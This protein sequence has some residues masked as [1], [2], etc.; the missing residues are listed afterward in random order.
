[1]DNPINVLSNNHI[2]SS[3]IKRNTNSFLE[4]AADREATITLKLAKQSRLEQVIP[5][6]SLI[7]I[8]SWPE[9]QREA[10]RG[11][12][13]IWVD[14]GLLQTKNLKEEIIQDLKQ[15][16]VEDLRMGPIT[17]TKSCNLC[18]DYD[19]PGHFGLITFA[20]YILNPIFGSEIVQVLRCVC[21]VCGALLVNEN[22]MKVAGILKVNYE[23][24]LK[25]LEKFCKGKSC[26]NHGTAIKPPEIV[27][28][29]IVGEGVVRRGKPENDEIP[30]EDN[31][32]CKI[33]SNAL[34]NIESI[35]PNVE[36]YEIL[37]KIT[38]YDA[39]LLGF[40]KSVRRYLED[41]L[42]D[43]KALEKGFL[44]PSHPRDMILQGSLVPPNI[45]RVPLF[46]GSDFQNNPITISYGKIADRAKKLR[47]FNGGI[48]YNP[49]ASYETRVQ[50]QY[51]LYR[52][53]LL[54]MVEAKK[55]SSESS[56]KARTPI[57]KLIQGKK[58]LMRASLMGKTN[59]YCARTVAGPDSDL[60][61]GQ[62]RLPEVWARVLT[63]RVTVNAHNID[64]LISLTKFAEPRIVHIIK[65]KSG[66]RK[67]YSDRFTLEIGDKVDRWLT[68]GDRVT[69]NRQPTLH[70]Q[71]LMAYEVVLKP[72]LTIGL[73]LSYTSPMNAD[74]DGDE[75]NTWI[76]QDFEVEAE[77]EIL[78]NVKH[79]LM[80]AE[81]NRPIMGLVMNSVSG[82][83]L[84]SNISTRIDDDLFQELFDLIDNP[85]K[86]TLTFRLAKYGVNARSGA[87]ILSALLP[88][89]FFY[90]KKKVLIVEGV[91]VSGRFRKGS[92]GPSNR[93][94][95]QDLY[96]AY[97]S[98]L[99]ARFFTNANWIINKWIYERGFTVGLLDMVNLK[100][101]PKTNLEY[102]ANERKLRQEL[103]KVYVE[104]EALNEVQ[105]DKI[106]EE[107]RIKLITNISNVANGIGLSLANNV[108]TSE[109]SIGVMTEKGAGT[110]GSVANIG[111]MMGS[112]GQQFYH[113]ER[114]VATLS[115][116]RRLLPSYDYDDPSPEAHGFVP[117][118]FFKGLSPQGLFFIHAGSRESLL[119]TAL[120]TADVGTIQHRMV[121][122]FEN[123]GIA[124]DGSV[125]N[126]A[127]TL[128]MPIYNSG[129]AVDELLTVEQH[130]QANASFFI[131]IV[132]EVERLNVKY[133]FVPK[134]V[135]DYV[136]DQ[137]KS[138]GYNDFVA[139]KPVIAKRKR[140]VP[141]RINKYEKAR[142][143]GAR[144]QQL[145]N[146][147]NPLIE[148]ELFDPVKIAMAEYDAKV[149]DIEVI[150]KYPDGRYDIVN[151]K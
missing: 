96:K 34:T 150:R 53:L 28:G 128:F 24:R 70:R 142:V 115:D 56:L 88:E 20:D 14:R 121:K 8:Y 7:T 104:I 90:N 148:T 92:I 89:T 126:T 57:V 19:C 109:N 58:A 67:L 107:Y 138:N 134:T 85:D 97:D 78:M 137:R 111:Q 136:L 113:G 69:V 47:E 25:L 40:S 79:N 60:K 5:V 41:G 83:Y 103:T 36:V 105:T 44:F 26:S 11:L 82:A 95:I 63:K 98:E 55:F 50:L 106:E 129:Y 102:D 118:S 45:T 51:Q 10:N 74:F 132:N 119:D 100:I 59:D 62:V 135:S 12:G 84:M 122:S 33:M 9:M 68:D 38:D 76:P 66:L 31:K 32:K 151:L 108:L 144:S 30:D 27:K 17:T 130:N 13:T 143:I 120:L 35:I 125:R 87:A 64:Y 80:S 147:A 112:V 71:S 48:K 131:D 77:C 21:H 75:L 42:T 15:G 146:G 94:I 81:Q 99:T 149:L 93:S 39:G 37:D 139:R 52:S 4:V 124:Y 91:L 117:D 123:I 3:I 2:S 140:F 86:N 101:D 145:M 114:L 23:K 116:G 18:Q 110:K 43:F 16:T 54:M 65:R 141:E 22:E 1:M 46:R 133:S 72:Y 49:N 73:H 29:C 127:G 61:F 6:K